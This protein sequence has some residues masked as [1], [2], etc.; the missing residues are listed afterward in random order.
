[1]I[2]QF[3]Y[4]EYIC[5]IYFVHKNH[6]SV[7]VLNLLFKVFTQFYIHMSCIIHLHEVYI[8]FIIPFT[9]T[10]SVTPKPYTHAQH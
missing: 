1:M 5:F 7:F 6:V 8:N 10:Y 9:F 2:D 3:Q 4:K